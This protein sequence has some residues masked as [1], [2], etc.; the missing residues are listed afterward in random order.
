MHK[1]KKRK[2]RPIIHFR[3]IKYFLRRNWYGTRSGEQWSIDNNKHIRL[4]DFGAIT[5]G[6]EKS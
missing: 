4:L 1:D 2:Y 3:N 6:Y 5:L